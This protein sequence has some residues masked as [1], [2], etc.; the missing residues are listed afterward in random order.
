MPVKVTPAKVATPDTA[1]WVR[2]PVP[3]PEQPRVPPDDVTVTAF[4]AVVTVVLVA[5]AM[6]MTGCVVSA[7]PEAPAA[8]AVVT[9]SWLAVPG[10]DTEIVVVCVVTPSG[11]VTTREMALV[12]P[13]AMLIGGDGEPEATVTP[14]IVIVEPA[15]ADGVKTR[16]SSAAVTWA[17]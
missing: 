3:P 10:R 7:D 2:Q 17:V 8:G 13:A 4:V 11:A 14:L 16:V 1:D 6:R 15:D 12:W 9:S 5:S